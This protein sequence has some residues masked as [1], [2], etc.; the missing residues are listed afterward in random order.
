MNPSFIE[1]AIGKLMDLFRSGD[2]PAKTAYT[3]IR[4]RSGDVRPSDLWSLGNRL[5]MLAYG[6]TDARG[7][8]QWSQVGRQVKPSSKA[9]YITAPIMKKMRPLEGTDDDNKPMPQV[10]GFRLIPVFKIEDTSGEPI[11]DHDYTPLATSLPPFFDVAEKLGLKVSYQ[12]FNG[13]ALGSYSP[14]TKQIKLS[15]QDAFVF[16]H[17]LAHAVDNQIEVIRPGRLAVAEI[18]A[19]MTAAVLCELQGITGYQSSTYD[20]IRHYST[21]KEPQAIL[22]AIMSVAGRVEEI[23]TTVLDTS[24]SRHSSPHATEVQASA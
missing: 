16:F 22:Q 2:F 7:Y 6:T 5:I 11:D 15:A 19:E 20:Y 8:G 13:R 12:P 21:S 1:G 18:T 17:E 9:F 4:R 14:G 10:I 24:A 23:V 3:I